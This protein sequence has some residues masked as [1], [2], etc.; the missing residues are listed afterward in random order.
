MKKYLCLVFAAIYLSAHAQESLKV[1]QTKK[2]T[3]IFTEHGDTRTDD[4]YWLNDP[5]D[6][7]V[8]PHLMQENAYT[9]AYMKPTEGLQKKIYDELVARIDQKYQSLATEKNNYWYYIR[10]EADSQYP[11][12]CR[13]KA[14]LSSPEKVYLNANKLAKGHKIYL[15]RGTGIS[16]D[17]KWLAYGIDTTGG[18]RSTL[19]LKNLATGFVLPETVN[20]TD[21]NYVWSNDNKTLYY[22]LN[23][24]T[25]RSYKVMKHVAGTDPTKDQYI[26]TEKD[27]TFSVYISAPNNNRFVFITAYSKTSTE[28]RYIDMLHP[29]KAPVLMQPRM[30]NVQYNADYYEGNSFLLT[31]NYKAKNFKVVSAPISHP[32]VN[33]WKDMIPNMPNALLANTVILKKYLVAEYKSKA[34]TQIKVINRVTGKSY[35]VPFKESA[36]VASMSEA[37]DNYLSD[38]IR[39]NYTSLTTPET[40]Y[41]FNLARKQTKLL[42]QQKIGGG[43]QASLYQTERLWVKARDGVMVPVSIVYKKSLFKK[44]G[45]NPTLLYAYGSYGYST[46]PYFNPSGISLLDRGFVFAIAHIRGGQEMGRYWYEDEGRLLHKKNTFTDFVDC[47]QYLVDNKYTASDK[48]FANGAS[49]GGMLMGAVINLRPDLFK[50]VLAEVPW[51]DV[52]TDMF[53]TDL[54]LTTLEYEEWGDPNKKDY[55]DYMVSWSPYDNIKKAKYPAILATG[56]LNDTQVPYF[57]PAK[58]VAKVRENNLGSSPV[59]FKVNMGAGHG[60]DSGRFDRQKLTALKYAFMLYQLGISQ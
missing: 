45:S 58:W 2:A 53:N 43:Y 52:V 31:T 40:D 19:Y 26:Y 10:Y 22:T 9:A 21:G 7:A 38:S 32:G 36:Y 60:G 57:S 27:S 39:Y 6:T 59:L 23:D 44:D 29:D 13:K 15:V 34:L 18:R 8:I 47:A 1:P 24:P 50:G 20:N 54:P 3:K 35:D 41:R 5:K 28:V 48:L 30:E 51:M 12:Y 17:G 14:M 49:A 55:Y 56:G 25:V 4:Y 16:P 33:N 11:L 37:T 42:K 46:D